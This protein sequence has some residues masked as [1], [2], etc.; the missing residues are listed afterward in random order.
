MLEIVCK[1][2]RKRLLKRESEK[3]NRNKKMM[4]ELIILSCEEMIHEVIISF[5][6]RILRQTGTNDDE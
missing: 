5:I 2:P 3:W 1:L 4:N 6:S